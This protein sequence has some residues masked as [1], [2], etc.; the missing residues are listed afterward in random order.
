MERSYG[1]FTRVIPLP[2]EINQDKVE[3]T[4]KKGVLI[5]TLPNSEQAIKET[6]KISVKSE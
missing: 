6:K 1:S 2:A 3:A 4:F 5:V